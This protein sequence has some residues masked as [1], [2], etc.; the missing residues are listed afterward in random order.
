MDSLDDITLL[1]EADVVWMLCQKAE[2]RG[3]AG[4]LPQVVW[5]GQKNIF[6]PNKKPNDEAFQSMVVWAPLG[7]VTVAC[8]SFRL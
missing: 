6:A 4:I 3:G 2:Y 1:R 8:P 5:Q 7:A